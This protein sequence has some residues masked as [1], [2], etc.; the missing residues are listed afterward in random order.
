MLGYANGQRCVST[1]RSFG[2][3]RAASMTM[4]RGPSGL[5]HARQLMRPAAKRYRDFGARSHTVPLMCRVCRD[6]RDGEDRAQG[7][8]AVRRAEKLIANDKRP[9]SCASGYAANG[10]RPNKTEVDPAE[11][12]SIG[13]RA[14]TL[15]S[16]VTRPERCA[17]EEVPA[18]E[19]DGMSRHLDAE[20][21]RRPGAWGAQP[22]RS[23]SGSTEDHIRRKS[24]SRCPSGV[25]PQPGAWSRL[26]ETRRRGE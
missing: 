1:S 19:W 3:C 9:A 11:F 16:W 10:G 6:G 25:P 24:G 14:P 4:K 2:S 15:P 12:P 21:V 13:G 26:S 7:R 17:G 8:R 20:A 22:A 5:R 23:G 18:C